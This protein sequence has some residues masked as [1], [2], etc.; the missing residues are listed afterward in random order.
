MTI[1]EETG[2]SERLTR[3]EI[4]KRSR[5]ALRTSNVGLG[6]LIE[7][8]EIVGQ[9][10][11]GLIPKSILEPGPMIV[12]F[13]TN[14][15][16]EPKDNDEYEL[17][18]EG[19]ATPIAS[20][21]LGPVSGRLPTVDIEVPTAPL[22]D[23]NSS[24][25]STTYKFQLVVYGGDNGNPDASSWM[26]V[27]IDRFAPEQDKV[28]GYKGQPDR[29]AFTNLPAS[30]IID[31]DWFKNNSALNITVNNAYLF[32]RADD[33]LDVYVDTLYGSPIAMP[34]YSAPL[35]SNIVSIPSTSLPKNNGI[36]Y[37]W[38]VLTDISTNV[39][40]PSFSNIFNVQRVPPPGLKDII[41]PK[42]TSPD[43]I[44][45]E[46]LQ[47]PVY[48][49]VPYTDNG[50]PTDLIQVN[51][52][53]GGLPISLGTQ[54]LGNPP[55]PLQYLART[56]VLLQLWGAATTELPIEANYKFNRDLENPVD[57]NNTTSALDFSY[58][59]P[60]NPAFPDLIH[61]LLVQV[62][63]VGDS[64]QANHITAE[65]RGKPVRIS[66]PM[67][68]APTTWTALGD[69]TV[70]FW[71][72]G[73]VIHSLTLTAGS[74]PAVF[75]FEIPAS[76]IDG[77]GDGRKFAGWSVELT[78]GRNVMRPR[79]TPV[80]VDAVRVVLPPPTVR[81]F[82]SFI[83]CRYLTVPNFELPVTVPIDATHMPRGTL[84]TLFSV[85]TTDSAGL[86]EIEGTEFSVEYTINGSETGGVFIRN[87]QPYLTKLKPIQPPRS[88]G[89][90]NGYMKI[91]YKV[92][93]AG[94]PT[95]STHFL[96]EVSL[97]NPS[98]N[99]C[100]GTPTNEA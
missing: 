39:S 67:I 41:I 66:T 47:T 97:L 15:I 22:V 62:T 81:L 71:Y 89:L 33:R 98:G 82:N 74:P 53:N 28:T 18:Q 64:G 91:W 43:V 4:A 5:L 1:Q 94:V 70:R 58:R 20:D 51:L 27:E 36:V 77:E 24:R 7:D 61:P 40:A 29:V 21:N 31:E 100:E 92:T 30:G 48:V 57:S 38:Y 88:S 65:D 87:I 54:P 63:V 16:K 42:G 45:L 83:S 79:D 9:I 23:N 80:D 99:Y 19:V 10:V 44:D 12:R 6:V 90:P 52:N 50:K 35:S 3:Q 68:Q 2:D 72:E 69:E 46:D 76:V 95:D 86:I 84:V 85:G 13:H 25:G 75:E 26:T 73:K 34:I 78:D 96:N 8:P 14:T 60:I 59:G 17:L 93:I 37:I 11:D 32:Y 49:N 56:N 55:G